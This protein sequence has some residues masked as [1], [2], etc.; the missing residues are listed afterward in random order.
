MQDFEDGHLY[1]LEK[2]WAFHQYSGLPKGAGVTIN[3][4]V[5]HSTAHASEPF[6]S[7]AMLW[8]LHFLQLVKDVDLWSLFCVVVLETGNFTAEVYAF[9][10]TCVQR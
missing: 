2:F 10:S 8:K 6:P 5:W 9:S 4:K 1:A 7:V 3:P